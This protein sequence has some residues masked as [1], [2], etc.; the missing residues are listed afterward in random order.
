MSVASR[1]LGVANTSSGWSSS[2]WQGTAH[3]PRLPTW[4]LIV[5]AVVR[6]LDDRQDPRYGPL[7]NSTW[8]Y[9]RQLV[10]TTIGMISRPQRVRSYE[11]I[12]TQGF[13]ATWLSTRG[14]TSPRR[15]VVP[16][17]SR[18]LTMAL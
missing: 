18:C 11:P 2:G 16:W 1:Y 13:I 14:R 15:G 6:R 10:M 12:R 4:R 3:S 7:G 9:D 5:S 17:P 8:L